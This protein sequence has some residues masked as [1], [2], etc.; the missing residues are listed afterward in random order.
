VHDDYAEG[1]TVAIDLTQPS[2]AIWQSYSRHL[3]Q[4]LRR[5]IRQGITV[6]PDPE[7][8]YLDEF[9]HMYHS[10]MKRNHAGEFYFFSRAYFE[11]LREALGPHGTLMIS[12]CGDEIA[13][14]SLLIEYSG[15]VNVHLLATADSFLPLSPSKLLIHETQAWARSRGN[16][17][18]HLGG[19]RGS[20]TD[21]PLF[22]FKSQFSDRSYP[23]Y[24]GRWI[25]NRAV[26]DALAAQ[27]SRQTT[28]APAP[29][30]AQQFFPAYRTPI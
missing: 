15:I 23:F 5:L 1:A 8:S 22:R 29:E 21:D 30:T 17:L 27:R 12:K 26:Y 13:A 2:E 10:T 14:A 3:H 11:R 25:L 4:A 24:T 20:R 16:R 19:G 6:K 9:I 28:S 7:W 18:V